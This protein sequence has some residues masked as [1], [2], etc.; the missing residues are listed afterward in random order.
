MLLLLSP[1]ITNFKTQLGSSSLRDQT[2]RQTVPASQMAPQYLTTFDLGPQA[3]AVQYSGISSMFYFIHSFSALDLQSV[4]NSAV[5]C[6]PDSFAGTYF[7][8]VIHCHYR[9]EY[10]RAPKRGG[11]G[12][13][14]T[15]QQRWLLISEDKVGFGFILHQ[16]Q[17]KQSQKQKALRGIAMYVNS[18]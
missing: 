10:K 5:L 12:W 9:A 16:E 18:S 7:V 2:S 4:L 1:A 15:H 8:G 13:Q 14:V 6:L 3:L 17:K 11:V